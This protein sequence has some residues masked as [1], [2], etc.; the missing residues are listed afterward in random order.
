MNNLKI[1]LFLLFLVPVTVFAQEIEE[2]E[3][4]YHHEIGIITGD[5]HISTDEVNN[6]RRNLLPSWGLFY[7][8]KFNEKWGIGLHADI[9]LEEFEVERGDN[10]EEF[11]ERK[12]PV[13]PAIMGLFKPT[14]HS[15]FMLGM[16][17][18]FSPEETLTLIRVEY[19]WSTP[20]GEKWEFIV[21]LSVDFRF[22]AYDVWN[23]GFG[24]VRL[25]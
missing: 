15:T 16:G 19:E 7:N 11:I 5:A 14:E 2:N 17:L 4:E 9:I 1:S 18:E 22:D 3:L 24:V 8:Y 25:F 23:L 12:Y 20:M 21:P 13:A 10:S 6:N